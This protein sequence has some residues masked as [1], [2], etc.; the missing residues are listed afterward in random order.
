VAGMS[1][2]GAAFPHGF[3]GQFQPISVVDDAVH[4]GVREGRVSLEK[5]DEARLERENRSGILNTSA[6]D[7]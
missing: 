2:G 7:G 1:Q 4:N 3:P 6:R 5:R